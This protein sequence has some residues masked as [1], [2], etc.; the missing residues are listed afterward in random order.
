MDYFRD[1]NQPQGQ[2]LG[3]RLKTVFSMS[4]IS[5]KTQEHLTRV[6]TLLLTCTIVCA[7]GM[8]VNQTF[9]VSGFFMNLASIALSIYFIFQVA[10]RQ[11]TDEWR[12]GCLAG[13][14]F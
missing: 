7:L 10:N 4:D 8:Y 11:N 9:I 1:R 6:Y 3:A 5:Q 12:K 13:L 2:G 14:A